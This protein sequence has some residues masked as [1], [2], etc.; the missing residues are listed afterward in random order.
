VE[1]FVEG[2][3]EWAVVTKPYEYLLGFGIDLAHAL[4]LVSSF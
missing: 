1:P 3:G 2:I 4:D